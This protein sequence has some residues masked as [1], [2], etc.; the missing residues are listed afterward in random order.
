MT[1]SDRLTCK[2][3]GKKIFSI[4]AL[5]NHERTHTGALPYLCPV[6]GC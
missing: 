4:S 5:N 1:D 2:Y 6:L 3:C